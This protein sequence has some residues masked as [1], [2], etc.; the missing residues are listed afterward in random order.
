M[1]SFLFIQILSYL[2]FSD[3]EWAVIRRHEP[4]GLA[5]WFGNLTS[6]WGR[7]RHHGATRPP[8]RGDDGSY[9][10]PPLYGD[11]T[12]IESDYL[13]LALSIAESSQVL[14]EWQQGDMVLIDVSTRPC[15]L[16]LTFSKELLI[17]KRTCLLIELRRHALS[18][19]MER[20]E[21]GSGGTLG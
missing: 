2:V 21:D 15:H 14:V 12:V 5:T 17:L 8:Y 6:A 9:H 19:A 11:G 13:D 7:S 16:V 18:H 4:T 10:P 3:T 20:K 1:T